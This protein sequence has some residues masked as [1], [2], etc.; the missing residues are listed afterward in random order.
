MCLKNIPISTTTAIPTTQPVTTVT[1][2]E[3][4]LQDCCEK[5]TLTDN[6]GIKS[7]KVPTFIKTKT[8]FLP[9]IYTLNLIV[10]RFKKCKD[11]E[12]F[13]VIKEKI[14]FLKEFIV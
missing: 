11:M 3:N 13:Y 14:L 6:I 8:Y 9:E 1:S 5:V 4:V 7:R 10:E 2:Y 12:F